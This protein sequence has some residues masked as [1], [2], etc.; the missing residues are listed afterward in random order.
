MQQNHETFLI[1]LVSVI[2][3][4]VIPFLANL[5]GRNQRAPIS[6]KFSSRITPWHSVMSHDIYH[7]GWCQVNLRCNM[8]SF[9]RIV[10]IIKLK[11]SEVNN[12]IGRN[13]FFLHRERVAVTMHYL[14]HSGS[15][16]DSAQCFGMGKASALRYVDEVLR[17]IISMKSSV[18]YFP[19]S[20]EQL[21]SIANEFEQIAGFPNVVGAIDG[22]LIE[23]QRPFDYEGWYC[24]KGYCAFNV[25]AIC[26]AKRRFLSFS[27]FPGSMNDKSMYKLSTFGKTCHQFIPSDK[28]LLG[29]A[30]YMLQNHLLIPYDIFELMP[31]DQKH[32]NYIHSKTRIA[33]EGAFGILKQ[34]FRILNTTLNQKSL[35][36][37]SDVIQACFVLH[38]IFIEM[39]D[40]VSFDLSMGNLNDNHENELYGV[41][42]TR[43]GY[44]KREQIKSYLASV[45]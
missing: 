29:D 16:R 32:Y 14:S 45:N 43:T 28:Q 18:I 5:D 30:G 17:V 44:H 24:R 39:N 34:R 20:S 26:D 27:I 38:N 42:S 41:T 37:M 31:A 40:D 36:G 7:D 35:T 25:Q 8:A 15:I 13:A 19:K 12:P 4:F 3:A 23:I 6:R 21:C 11:W 22:T 9:K 10:E 33:I 1:S 2:V